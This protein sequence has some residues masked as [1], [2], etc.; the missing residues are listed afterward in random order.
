MENR[1]IEKLLSDFQ[2]YE[3]VDK[4][5]IKKYESFF[6]KF[7]IEIWNEYGFGSFFHGLFRTINPEDEDF[8]EIAKG[9]GEHFGEDTIPMLLTGMND[10][11]VWKKDNREEGYHYI[12]LRYRDEKYT[13]ISSDDDF[14]FYFETLLKSGHAQRTF[15]FKDFDIKNYLELVEKKGVPPYDSGFAYKLPLA[16]GG[17]QNDYSSMEIMGTKV[18]LNFILSLIGEPDWE[19]LY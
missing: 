17:N 1:E 9:A 8:R 14:E 18:N 12:I 19:P 13:S 4:N 16:L 11:I 10:L 5:T 2:F 15:T 3:K 6:P 7:L